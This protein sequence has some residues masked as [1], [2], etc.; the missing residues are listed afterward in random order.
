MDRMAM[1]NMLLA[2]QEQSNSAYLNDHIDVDTWAK[3]LQG[4][5]EKLS[6]VGLRLASRPWE[7]TTTGKVKPF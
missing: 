5:D 3:E 7:T 1:I 2:A 4:I 6:V